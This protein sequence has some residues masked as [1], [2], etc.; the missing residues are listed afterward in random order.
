MK[1]SAARAVFLTAALVTTVARAADYA[2]TYRGD[3][4]GQPSSVELTKA[5]GGYVGTIR[6][7]TTLLPCR[8]AEQGD[9]LA[10][11]FTS[12][13][14]LFDFT[15]TRSAD[16]LT[17]CTAGATYTLTGQPPA[18][19]LAPA[20]VAAPAPPVAPAP[21]ADA[22]AE[23][24]PLAT[25]DTGRAVVFHQP[26]ATTAA[27]ALDATLPLLPRAVG[28][29]ITVTGR[30]A[31]TK[32][33]DRGGASFTATVGGRPLH[34]VAFAGRSTPGGEDV[35]VAY[36][37]ADAPAAEWATLTA[38][39]P[40]PVGLREF[41]FP[42]GTG[43]IGVPE[44][45]TCRSN[46]AADAVVVNGP[47]GQQVTIGQTIALNGQQSPLVQSK[48]GA[49]EQ[50]RQTDLSRRR[51]DM[52]MRSM[53]LQPTAMPP[54]PPMPPQPPDAAMGIFYGEFDDPL[55]MLRRVYPQLSEGSQANHGP[56]EQIDRVLA[57]TPAQPMVQG[58]RADLVSMLW[59]AGTGATAEHFRFQ[60]RLESSSTG[61]DTAL[62]FCSGLRAHPDRFDRD[63]PT[64]WAV[65]QSFKPNNEKIAQIGQ[66][67]NQKIVA[68]GKQLRDNQQAMF[69][70]GQAIHNQQAESFDRFESS[71][72]AQS[73]ASHRAA[74]DAAEMY[75]GYQSIVNTRT[76]ERK[77]VDYY[78]S[79]GIVGA[80]N[81]QAHDPN[82]W[83]VV[84]RRD[85][86]YPLG[87]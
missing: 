51:L 27:A 36:C 85:E 4:K 39:L 80:L 17:L 21:P 2:G 75:S 54:M 1:Q 60:G 44:G 28:G 14:A 78:N 86:Q 47:D 49:E 3:I 5:N 52:Q 87:R 23:G 7:G 58:G 18:N 55:T 69:D 15:A 79:D 71:I 30:F 26:A 10:G 77:E 19:P 9:H 40:H 25:T 48:R 70:R 73:T 13:G 8:G 24:L 45:W 74:S 56:P 84:H 42:D 72:N 11:T 29:P 66:E 50:K 64:L 61:Y 63:L 35:S 59:S 68:L 57:V 33:P 43:S 67:N 31:D 83:T 16:T 81:D 12:G 20:D 46:S 37:A 62:L 41:D 32:Q 53:G 76:G 65:I 22:P 34:G 38:A 82:E 6:L